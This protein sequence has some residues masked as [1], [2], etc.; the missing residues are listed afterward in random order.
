MNKIYFLKLFFPTIFG[1]FLYSKTKKQEAKKVIMTKS[2]SDLMDRAFAC[3]AKGL[4]FDPYYAQVSVEG[5]L[6]SAHLSL[7]HPWGNRY[8]LSTFFKKKKIL[9]RTL[10]CS[11]Y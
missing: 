4:E 1:L 9:T 5:F 10:P 3:G 7:L 8:N 6:N 11:G 2:T